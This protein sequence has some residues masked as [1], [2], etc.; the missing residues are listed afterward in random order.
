VLL[1]VPAGQE[2]NLIYYLYN[3]KG[4]LLTTSD[5]KRTQIF[6]H[7]R[8]DGKAAGGPGRRP[9]TTESPQAL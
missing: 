4:Q 9:A 5:G 2:D 6:G 3:H 8:M 7:L 1:E